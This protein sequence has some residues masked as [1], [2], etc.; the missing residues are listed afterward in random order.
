MKSL[1]A[2]MSFY[3]RYHRSPRNKATHFIGVPAIVLSVMLAL[4][5]WRFGDSGLSAAELVS[6][7]TL[8][9]YFRLDVPLALA[10]TV[11]FAVLLAS[12]H[13]LDNALSPADARIA[14]VVLFLGGWVLQLL[15]HYFEGR[16]PAL[17]DNLFQVV[18]AP[19]FLVAEVFFHF[20]YKPG[21]RH[22]V[23]DGAAKGV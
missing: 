5:W 3:Q 1:A 9:Y 21:L 19:I 17:A 2:Q 7:V 16:K 11:V 14:F 18:I 13:W 6:L 23:E 15:G 10:S 22:E 12:A 8:A 4:S 20:G